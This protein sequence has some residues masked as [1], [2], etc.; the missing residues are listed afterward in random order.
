MIGLGRFR[1]RENLPVSVRKI[2]GEHRVV[3]VPGSARSRIW[4]GF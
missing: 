1:R 2:L 4:L 3:S